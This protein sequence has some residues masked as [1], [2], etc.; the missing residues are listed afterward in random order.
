MLNKPK[1]SS[2]PIDGFCGEFM[3]A[4]FPLEQ[5][6]QRNCA[7]DERWHHLSRPSAQISLFSKR[8]PSR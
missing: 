4:Q 5:I 7:T 6:V 2:E 8:I 3:D 1:A